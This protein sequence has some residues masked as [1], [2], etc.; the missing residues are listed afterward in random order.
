[1]YLN[2]VVG[3]CLNAL[4]NYFNIIYSSEFITSNGYI[5][6]IFSSRFIYDVFINIL[7]RDRFPL[8][9]PLNNTPLIQRI[10]FRVDSFYILTLIHRYAIYT[11]YIRHI[12][13]RLLTIVYLFT[14]F[15][16][17]ANVVIH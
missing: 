1:M 14:L 5:M 15:R 4:T 6:S 17:K 2:C 12:M 13:R 3:E 10:L 11:I 9:S 7:S 16:I 8:S